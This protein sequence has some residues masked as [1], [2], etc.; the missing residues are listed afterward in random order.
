MRP[1]PR[2]RARRRDP[3][4]SQARIRH[5]RA[6]SAPQAPALKPNKP[7]DDLD[8][9]ADTQWAV[10]ILHLLATLERTM[11][12]ARALMAALPPSWRKCSTAIESLWLS[13]RRHV[14]VEALSH[15]TEFKSNQALLRDIGA[16]MEEAVWQG[17]TNFPQPRVRSRGT[18]RTRR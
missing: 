7:G 10:R 1:V 5:G 4:P 2:S 8:K 16:A 12:F 18:A 13:G 3:A 14:K 11:D 6:A 9:T 17:S 15:S